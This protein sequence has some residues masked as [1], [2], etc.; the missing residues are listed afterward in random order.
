[1]TEYQS[2]LNTLKRNTLTEYM[3]SSSASARNMVL[4]VGPWKDLFQ[5]S[6]L[7]FPYL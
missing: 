4:A 1:M 3:S 7:K 5:F 2:E 6:G